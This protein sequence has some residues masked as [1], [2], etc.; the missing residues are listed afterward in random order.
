MDNL[1]ITVFIEKIKQT[2]T[3]LQQLELIKEYFNTVSDKTNEVIN[4]VNNIQVV[5][6]V[7]AITDDSEHIV[8]INKENLQ[9]LL[10]NVSFITARGYKIGEL[11]ISG[12][13][14]DVTYLIAL[15]GTGETH[16]YLGDAG[17][18]YNTNGELVISTSLSNYLNPYKC[19]ITILYK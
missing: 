3:V 9:P 15:Y 19:S 12:N 5:D 10:I 7:E 13:I 17:I 1:D 11:N 6:F 2:Y 4:N 18:D 16:P 8:N 14:K